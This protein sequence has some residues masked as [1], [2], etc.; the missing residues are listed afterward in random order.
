[1]AQPSLTRSEKPRILAVDSEKPVLHRLRNALERA[2]YEVTICTDAQEAVRHLVR[3]QFDCVITGTDLASTDGFELVR[4]IRK[5]LGILQIPVLMMSHHRD[6]HHLK[7]AMEVGA[8]DYLFKPVDEDLLVE[9]IEDSLH[10]FTEHGTGKRAVHVQDNPLFKAQRLNPQELDMEA[11]I[12]IQC[13]IHG[14]TET[15]LTIRL[16]FSLDCLS[17]L[18]TPFR[19]RS[20]IFE[21]IGIRP[22]LLKV[23]KCTQLNEPENDLPTYEASLAFENLSEEEAD[24]VSDWLKT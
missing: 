20:R 15:H 12:G 23:Q 16:P 8:T 21:E 6:R 2:R 22:P 18:E 13:R 9:K 19:L 24:H 10:P 7:R 4:M 11:E 1:M 5:N 17:E 3:E 14:I